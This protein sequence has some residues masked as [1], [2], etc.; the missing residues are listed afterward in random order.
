[1]SAVALVATGDLGEGGS[2]RR[3]CEFPDF[4]RAGSAVVLPL[5]WDEA[6]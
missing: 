4:V 5:G 2:A 3:N 1:M 6:S